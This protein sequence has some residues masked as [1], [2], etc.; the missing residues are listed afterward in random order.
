MTYPEFTVRQGSEIVTFRSHFSTCDAACEALSL[1]EH[2]SHFAIDLIRAHRS[3]RISENQ[4]AWLHKIATEVCSPNRLRINLRRI[5]DLMFDAEKRVGS[6]KKT[7]ITIHDGETKYRLSIAGPT[8][9]RPGCV[10]VVC[11]EVFL[12]RINLEGHWEPQPYTVQHHKELH[13]SAETFLVAMNKDPVGFA[14]SHG[15][16]SGICMFCSRRLDTKESVSVGYG[17]VCA[18]NWGLP[19]GDKKTQEEVL[20]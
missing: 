15:A 9:K 3:G 18:E 8:S 20:Q 2:K 11:G 12:G 14:V 4:K 6:L 17:P 10:Y 13:D 19:W 16:S 1:L 5:R 7:K